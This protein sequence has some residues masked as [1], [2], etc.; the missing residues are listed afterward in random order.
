MAGIEDGEVRS[1]IDLATLRK[2]AGISEEEK[3]SIE[4]V[5]IFTRVSPDMLSFFAKPQKRF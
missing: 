3:I 4:T 1:M 2:F 5:E